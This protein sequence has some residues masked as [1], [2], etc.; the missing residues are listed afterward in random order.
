VPPPGGHSEIEEA[1]VSRYGL[2]D[3]VVADAP[4]G[5]EKAITSAVGAAAASYLEDVL[6]GHERIG[7]SSWSETL[8]AMVTVLT[9]RPQPVA[10]T[11]AQV[12]GGVGIPE[13]QVQA[14]RLTEQLAA[15]TGGQPLFLPTPGVVSGKALRDAMLHEPYVAQVVDTWSSLTVLLAG[16]GS[17]EPSPLLRRSGNA[18]AESDQEVL[19]DLG[20]VGDICL[21]FF[22]ADGGHVHSDLDGRV[23]GIEPDALLA[24]PRRIG[25]AGGTRK[26]SAIRASV[27]GGWVN[28]L[29]TDVDTAEALLA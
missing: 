20:A 13:A 28:V 29:V 26:H 4:S 25:V 23:V 18:I 17:L 10:D 6:L 24:V 5:D 7:I 15:L 1:L 12:I 27:L 19:R 11:V 22:D 2:L 9:R 21:R 8:L 16:I 3:A 14:T